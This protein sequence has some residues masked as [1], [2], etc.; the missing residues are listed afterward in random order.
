M[1]LGDALWNILEA[2]LNFFI[3]LIFERACLIILISITIPHTTGFSLYQPCYS[4]TF[5][6]IGTPFT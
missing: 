1:I 6:T 5:T 2:L 4:K 3:R